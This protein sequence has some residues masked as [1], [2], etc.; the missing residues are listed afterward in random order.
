M[1][2]PAFTA[3]IRLNPEGASITLQCRAAWALLQLVEAGTAGCTPLEHSGPRW[4]G[5]VHKWLDPIRPHPG[6]SSWEVV[7]P[8]QRGMAR[9]QSS[10]SPEQPQKMTATNKPTDD[11]AF[12][13][14]VPYIPPRGIDRGKVPVPRR[15]LFRMGQFH[16][17]H[18]FWADTAS[19][20]MKLCFCT[21]ACVIVQRI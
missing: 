9:W 8:R 10:G 2:S 17:F 12:T 3:T 4:S 21:S 6:H 19:P 14:W 7:V 18:R 16:Q 5:Y 20:I 11:N 13:H 15:L 1:A